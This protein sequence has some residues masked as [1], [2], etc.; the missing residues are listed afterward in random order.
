MF[1]SKK[2]IVIGVIV[3]ILLLMQIEAFA[4]EDWER[5]TELPTK[6]KGFATAVIDN[7]V[8]LIGGS[9]F[10]NVKLNPGKRLQGPFGLSTVEVYETQTNRWRR[11]ADMPTPRTS[12]RAAVVNGI[13]YVFGGYSGKDNRGMNLNFPVVVETY[14]P[15]TDT[16]TQKRD[17]P[18]SRVEFDLGVAAGRIY[19][20]G[21]STGFGAGYEKRTGRVDIYDPATDTWTEGHKMPTRR[22]GMDV[23]VVSKRIYALGGMGWPQSPSAPG[24]FLTVIEAYNPITHQWERDKDLLDLR[25]GFSTVVVEDDIYLIGGFVWEDGPPKYLATVDVYHPQTQAWHEIPSLPYP[26]APF[27][28]AAVNG[29]I[30]VFG[31][32]GKGF[33]LFSDVVVFDTRSLREVEGTGKRTTH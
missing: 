6:R 18:F 27:R 17:M 7:K 12:A 23:V 9:L 33:S 10:E 30:Y 8:Y 31:G 25:V 20:I 28:A 11:V 2:V 4:G 22:D 19:L 3:F 29:K 16:W 15:T 26:I 5:I 21:G 13:I 1:S 14:D 24:P 32:V